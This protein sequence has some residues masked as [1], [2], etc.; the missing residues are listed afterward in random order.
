MNINKFKFFFFKIKINQ[1]IKLFL[2]KISNI[3]LDLMKGNYE[4]KDLD[5]VVRTPNFVADL[6]TK[7]IQLSQISNKV[8]FAK[9]IYHCF[10]LKV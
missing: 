7:L 10:I 4:I 3:I 8:Y 9:M 5:E 2:L 6:F 1:Y